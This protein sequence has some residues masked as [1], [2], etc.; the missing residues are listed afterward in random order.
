M[1]FFSFFLFLD[2]MSH[3]SP[4]TYFSKQAIYEEF[5]YIVLFIYS[6]FSKQVNCAWDGAVYVLSLS[7]QA[8]H[9]RWLVHCPFFIIILL[10]SISLCKQAIYK[11]L[12]LSFSPL[13]LSPS[14]TCTRKSKSCTLPLPS[15]PPAYFSHSYSRRLD[16]EKK[17][18]NQ[19]SIF[20]S[21]FLSSQADGWMEM[22]EEDGSGG[23]GDRGQ[24]WGVRGFCLFFNYF[25]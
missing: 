2:W 18:K 23:E 14:L 3:L 8:V 16:A 10:K 19:V 4:V 15:P 22:S 13:P 12:H 25:C 9:Y 24:V 17:K 11:T 21:S 20:L 5:A 7:K 1:S 6:L